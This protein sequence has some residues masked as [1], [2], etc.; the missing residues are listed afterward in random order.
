MSQDADL[1]T[2]VRKIVLSGTKNCGPDARNILAKASANGKLGAI[3]G[4]QS[5]VMVVDE[6]SMMHGKGKAVIFCCSE[7]DY[8][9]DRFY[10]STRHF[11][12]IHMKGGQPMHRKRKY[13]KSGAHSQKK[14]KAA[15]QKAPQ[16]GILSLQH[17]PILKAAEPSICNFVQCVGQKIMK[18]GSK[19]PELFAFFGDLE[20]AA[21]QWKDIEKK[22]QFRVQR[23]EAEEML[24]SSCSFSEDVESFQATCG[25]G[26]STSCSA[27]YNSS[28]EDHGFSEDSVMLLN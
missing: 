12:R 2:L 26:S 27:Y 10:H 8:V 4:A 23:E 13:T 19:H 7:C 1:E 15:S 28:E 22:L 11:E 14:K 24:M 20:D 21:R 5:L 9:G 16:K 6:Q 18:M 25:E 3:P 17:P